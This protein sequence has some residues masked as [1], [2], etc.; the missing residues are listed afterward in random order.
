MILKSEVVDGVE[1]QL[2]ENR[3]PH[4]SLGPRY[5]V[6]KF[7]DGTE[8]LTAWGLSKITEVD[9]ITTQESAFSN[10]VTTT[11]PTP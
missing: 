4:D 8:K 5:I 11:V 9:S 3:N 2:H 6:K 7:S 10:K 1:W